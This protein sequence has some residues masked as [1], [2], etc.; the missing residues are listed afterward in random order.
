MRY[1]RYGRGRMGQ[2][3]RGDTGAA[4]PGGLADWVVQ[5]LVNPVT[6]AS[7]LLSWVSD[8]NAG[9][10]SDTNGLTSAWK[11]FR[12]RLSIANTGNHPPPQAI[13]GDSRSPADPSYVNGGDYRLYQRLQASY[14]IKATGLIDSNSVHYLQGDAPR[15]GTTREPCSGLQLFSKPV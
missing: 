5:D 15:P 13:P 9:F 7:T 10:G 2:R 4:R 1:P 6:C 12:K 3:R 14:E 8:G 11:D